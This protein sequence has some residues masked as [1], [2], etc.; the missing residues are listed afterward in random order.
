MPIQGI[1]YVSVV[2]ADLERSKRFYGETLGWKPGTDQPG[3]A[4]FHL[5]EGYLVVRQAAEGEPAAAGGTLVAVRV[6]GVDAEHAR[7]Q[8]AG[9]PVSEVRDQP[10][11]ERSFTFTDPDGAAW[12]YAQI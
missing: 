5:G 12:S 7:L 8:A 2:A 6:D 3:V 11:G 10:W 9:V 1:F 4:G